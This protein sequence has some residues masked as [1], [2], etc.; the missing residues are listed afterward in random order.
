MDSLKSLEQAILDKMLQGYLPGSL[1]VC[2]AA[3]SEHVSKHF[4]EA[5]LGLM[6]FFLQGDSGSPDKQAS[7]SVSVFGHKQ[8]CVWRAHIYT[9]LPPLRSLSLIPVHNHHTKSVYTSSHL[10]HGMFNSTC[11]GKFRS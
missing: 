3:Q 2:R 5:V 10:S 9:K 1:I 7:V 8:N 6:S 4:S 11:T